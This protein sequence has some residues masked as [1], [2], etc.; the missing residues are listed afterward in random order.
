MVS[1]LP[2]KAKDDKTRRGIASAK[3]RFVAEVLKNTVSIVMNKNV[4]VRER[5]AF[6]T[7]ST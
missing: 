7:V 6:E 4:F 3:L 5:Q 2:L 1:F